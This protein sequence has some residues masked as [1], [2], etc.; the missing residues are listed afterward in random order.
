MFSFAYI[1]LTDVCLVIFLLTR[2]L[3]VHF[4]GEVTIAKALK[5]SYPSK[6][7]HLTGYVYDSS[8]CNYGSCQF[9]VTVTFTNYVRNFN[10]Y[11]LYERSFEKT[12]LKTTIRLQG[13]L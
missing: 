1:L 8:A 2:S 7:Y 11:Y 5:A 13:R 10:S 6:K 4:T 3:T 9:S 12:D